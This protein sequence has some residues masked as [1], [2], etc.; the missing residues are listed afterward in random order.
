MRKRRM[1]RDVEE[2]GPRAGLFGS[3]C[4]VVAYD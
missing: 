1:K 2:P 3:S 4:R